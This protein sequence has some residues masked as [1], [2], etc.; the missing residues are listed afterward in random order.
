VQ[1]KKHQAETTVVRKG[2][3]PPKL[4]VGAF[5][6]T[7]EFAPAIQR[8]MILPKKK[9]KKTTS[10][11]N[12]TANSERKKGAVICP[13]K[14]RLHPQLAYPKKGPLFKKYF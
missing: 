4:T 3:R 1:E 7:K 10:K 6:Q 12:I 14:A 13:T 8:T 11:G 5:L 9:K 2:N